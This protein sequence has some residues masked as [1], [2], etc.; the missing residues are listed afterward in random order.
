M[1]AEDT[2]NAY[3]WNGSAWIASGHLQGPAGP[4][5]PQGIQGIQGIPGV[6]GPAGPQGLVGPP[7]ADGTLGLG[8]TNGSDAKPGIVGEFVNNQASANFPAGSL[9]QTVTPLT[10]APGDW[11]VDA[12]AN[13]QVT[14]D[15]LSLR[16]AT[17]TNP[18]GWSPY[19]SYSGPPVA[20]CNL[21]N[22]MRVN[23]TANT[24][25]DYTVTT[26]SDT[27]GTVSVFLQARRAR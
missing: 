16:L 12:A 19:A 8:V 14:S 21:T 26:Q 27:P 7:G 17:F 20:E 23:V 3:V 2:G 5:G 9:T 25:M 6:Q 18:I 22:R 15:F 24:P 4:A 1:I 11:D 13:F 10:L